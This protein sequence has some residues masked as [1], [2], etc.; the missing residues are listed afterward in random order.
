M[1]HGRR[2]ALLAGLGLLLGCASPTEAQYVQ[3]QTIAAL[4]VTPRGGGLDSLIIPG[5]HSERPGILPPELETFTGRHAMLFEVAAPD[6]NAPLTIPASPRPL[7]PAT[8]MT[9]GEYRFLRAMLTCIGMPPPVAGVHAAYYYSA[10]LVFLRSRRRADGSW[11]CAA[12]DAVSPPVPQRGARRSL[13]PAS[14]G[15]AWLRAMAY[16][17]GVPV[18][19]LQTPQEFLQGLLA[20][21]ED[22]LLRFV[23]KAARETL[24]DDGS[25]ATERAALD[26]VATVLD[27]DFDEVRRQAILGLADGD[28]DRAILARH[29]LDD[30]NRAFADHL[31]P[32]LRNERLVIAM[33][34]AH[35]GEP[36]GIGH[37]LRERG[38]DVVPV[39]IRT[40]NLIR[41]EL[42]PAP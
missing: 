13:A 2:L 36:N 10:T 25:G 3:P 29:L 15:D 18:Q 6:G 39:R 19:G 16:N 28:A 4:R 30:R 37:F 23:A 38:F 20:I 22:T 42:R 41:R 33:G 8:H 7:D 24:A 1:H 17:H 26:L 11:G 34:A 31:A 32:R 21:P 14:G 12:L 35:A 5:F 27:G 40:A 9:A